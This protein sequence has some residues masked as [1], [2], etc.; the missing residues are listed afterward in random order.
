MKYCMFFTE[1]STGSNEATYL[2]KLTA[3]TISY[4]HLVYENNIIIYDITATMR[5]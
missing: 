3:Y 2:S 5:L 1:L 4:K